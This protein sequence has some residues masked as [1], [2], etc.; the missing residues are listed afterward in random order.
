[1][2]AIYIT[3]LGAVLLFSASL[4]QAD[5]TPVPTQA[6]QK[7]PTPV[8]HNGKKG[9]IPVIPSTRPNLYKVTLRIDAQR[10]KITDAQRAGRITDAQTQTLR[11]AIKSIT[12]QKYE[13][14][15]ENGRQDF[16]IDQYNQI[17]KM[18][19]ENGKDIGDTGDPD[20][21]SN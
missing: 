21:P 18:L 11:E 12:K 9:K 17:E 1:M 7:T 3:I 15:K 13:W 4:V 5:P 8:K 14:M 6:P 2:K 19:D 20:T 10:Q 16:S